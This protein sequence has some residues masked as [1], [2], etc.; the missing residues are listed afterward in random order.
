MQKIGIL[1]AMR[2]E[3]APLL[4]LFGIDFEEISLGGN[5]FHKG[6]Y[7]DKEIVI[8]YSKIGKVHSTL[9]TTSMIL[10]FG[11]KKVLFSG[12]AGSLI[13]DLKINDLLIANK[14]VQHDVD[15]SAFNHPLGFIPESEVFVKTSEELNA[16]AKVVAK[17]QGIILKEGVIASGDQFVHSKERKEFLIKEFNASAVEMEGA[18]VAFVCEKFSVPCCVLRSIS[19]NAD[20]DADMSFDDFLEQSAK[21]SAQ[22]LK[23]MVD[24]L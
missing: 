12:V 10:H 5:V 9:T 17:E 18:S 22:F 3:I 24:K 6:I 23:S 4:E 20:E 2:E 16:L 8:A 1:G 11:V 7:Q 15:L 19:D 13:K 21:T 14:L